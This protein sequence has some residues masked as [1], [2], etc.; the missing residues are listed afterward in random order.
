M[1]F[2]HRSKL[3]Q[4]TRTRFREIFSYEN[5]VKSFFLYYEVERF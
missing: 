4:Q 5:L 3:I 1:T 2:S